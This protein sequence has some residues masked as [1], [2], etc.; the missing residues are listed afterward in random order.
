MMKKLASIT[1]VIATIFV[2]AALFS[3]PL[4]ALLAR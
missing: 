2:L 1:L 4:M 3:A